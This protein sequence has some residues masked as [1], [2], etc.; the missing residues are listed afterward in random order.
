MRVQLRSRKDGLAGEGNFEH[1][2]LSRLYSPLTVSLIA[3]IAATPALAQEAAPAP[4]TVPA[5]AQAGEQPLTEDDVDEIVVTAERIRGQV[6]TASAPV[7]ELDAQQVAAYGAASISD[8]VAQ[9]APA[10]GSGN[11]RGG[12]PV[13]LV[14]GQ[15]VANFREIG[16]YPPESIKKVEV[17]PE[18]V[19]LKFGYSASQRVINFILQDNYAS[20]EIE[21]EAGMP[22]RGGYSTAEGEVGILRIDGVQRLN[23]TASYERTSPLT[24]AE[25]GIVQTP[26]SVPTVATDPDPAEFRTLVARG[27]QFEAN[28]TGTSGLGE[29]GSAGQFT[30]NSQWI[31]SRSLSQSGLDLSNVGGVIRVIDDNPIERRTNTD[32]LAIGAGYSTRIGTYQFQSTLDAGL[33]DT[34]SLIDRRRTAPGPVVTD[35]ARSKVWTA[36]LRN[37]LIGNPVLLPAGEMGVTLNAA[38]DWDRIE[39]FDTR[40]QFGGN[41]LT[42]GALSLGSNISIPI[43]SKREDFLPALGELTATLSGGIEHLSDFGTLGNIN[44]GLIWR[45]AEPLTLQANYSV[46]EAAPGLT[47]LGGPTIVSFNVPVYDFRANQ[48]VLVTQTSGGNPFLKAETQRD[49]KLSA[50]YDIDILDRANVLVEYYRTNSSD[51]TNGFPLLT[52][53]T[54]AAFPDRVTRDAATGRLTALDV[55]PVTFSEVKSERLRYGIN[56]FGKLGKPLPESQRQSGGGFGAMMARAGGGGGGQAAPTTGAAPASTGAQGEAGPGRRGGGMAMG[57]DP[58]RFRQ[59]REQF[60]ASPAGTVPDLSALPQQMQDRLKGEDGKVDPARVAVMRERFCSSDGARRFDP[61]RFTAMRQ[62]LC[63]DMTKDPDP[64]AI[65]EDIRARIAGPDGSISPTRLKEFRDRICALPTGQARGEGRGEGGTRRGGEG[66]PVVIAAG[67]PP[68]GAGGAGGP[69][70]GPRGGGSRGGGGGFGPM[71]GGGDGT[72]RW[73]LA[74]YHTVNLANS[75]LIAPG[76]PFLDLLDGDATGNGG[77]VSRHLIELEGGAFYRGVGVRL[78]GNYRSATTVRGTGLPGS[79]D[80]NFGDLATFNLRTFVALDQQKWLVGEGDA[81]FFKNARL[82]LNV[83]NIFDAR[84]RVTDANGVVPLRYQPFL[85]DPVGR[86]VEIEFRKL[87]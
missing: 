84:Q 70:G 65:P 18:E 55:R 57:M 53:A 86:F 44:A 46:R 61:A 54:E 32:T 3:L 68:G 83:N 38:Y 87:F 76:G 6:Q 8:L 2:G 17:L 47:Q 60:C 37:T 85:T 22:T 79:S 10:V 45:P 72:G 82:S 64:S 5:T 21:I 25:R 35:L 39:S 67:P 75:V 58:E 11:G 24:E 49:L 52:P 23:A 71:G 19:A 1:E 63:A 56:L 15:R 81:G 62:A 34:E 12:R 14:N 31:H 66:G 51:V 59:L 69:G 30:L 9:L 78:A 43:A 80:L 27:D 16:R 48:T 33:T 41:T 40:T 42:R 74:L 13:I 28:I 20:R 36:G 29:E 77:G 4:A 73:N 26:G 7:I 50:S